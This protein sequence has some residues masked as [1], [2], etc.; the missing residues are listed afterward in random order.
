MRSTVKMSNSS[1]IKSNVYTLYGRV[2]NCM[3]SIG[4]ISMISIQHTGVPELT[5]RRWSTSLARNSTS[6]SEAQLKSQPPS[7]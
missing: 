1:L 6:P 7:D 5:C 2:W 3:E 4:V